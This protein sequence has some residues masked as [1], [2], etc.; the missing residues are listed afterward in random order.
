M[1]IEKKFYEFIKRCNNN[2]V[3]ING[4][5]EVSTKELK[6]AIDNIVVSLTELSQDKWDL[7]LEYPIIDESNTI[8]IE[9]L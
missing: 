9:K 3:L 2:G 1:N 8:Y 5:Y 4:E 7:V 6:E